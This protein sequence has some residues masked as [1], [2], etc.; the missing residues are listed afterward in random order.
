MIDRYEN[1]KVEVAD[2]E[3]VIRCCLDEAQ[4]DVQPS[5]SG[6]LYRKP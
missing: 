1:V 3:L 4:V 2:G 6:K 5:G